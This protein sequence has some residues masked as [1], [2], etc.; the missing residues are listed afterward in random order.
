MLT[1][2]EGSSPFRRTILSV[3]VQTSGQPIR[4]E[5][6][7]RAACSFSAR[8]NHLSFPRLLSRHK[9]SLGGPGEPGA[10]SEEKRFPSLPFHNRPW[11]LSRFLGLNCLRLIWGTRTHTRHCICPTVRQSP[12]RGKLFV[13]TMGCPIA[14]SMHT[15]ERSRTAPTE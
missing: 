14:S 9:G 5:R 3:P 13:P 11:Q 10:P 12:F 15:A 8:P 7:V 4:T 6:W 2:R 1:R